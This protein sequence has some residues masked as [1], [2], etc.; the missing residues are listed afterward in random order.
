MTTTNPASS[1]RPPAIA[2]SLGGARIGIAVRG[3]QILTDQPASGGGEDSA[4]TPIE[5]LG[6][7]LAGCIVLYVNRFCAA[8]D[9]P[10]DD[11]QVLVHPFWAQNPGRIERFE[12][13]LRLPPSIPE[14]L[15]PLLERVALTC[16][17]HHT[18]TQAPGIT[19][20]LNPAAT[21][22]APTVPAGTG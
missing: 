5:L 8:R 7:A 3:H 9:L 4:P 14:K 20:R 11:V 10:A 1:A 12:V 21:E 2:S 6:A 17:V 15:Y 19:V 16:P 18:L 22:P 13:E